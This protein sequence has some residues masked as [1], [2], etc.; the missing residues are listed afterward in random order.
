M[1]LSGLLFVFFLGNKAGDLSKEM[2]LSRLTSLVE[3]TKESWS[4]KDN[5]D[6]TLLTDNSNIAYIRIEN[7]SKSEDKNDVK[8]TDIPYY[9]EDV[10]CL[11][12]SENI[13]DII[14]EEEINIL[15]TKIHRRW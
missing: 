4:D 7:I 10:I 1:C 3:S 12:F 9:P 2:T 8:P 5:D 11:S 13:F 15:R 14:N 6:F